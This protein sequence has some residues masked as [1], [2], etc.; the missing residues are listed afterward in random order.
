M[1][2]QSCLFILALSAIL[3]FAATQPSPQSSGSERSFLPESQKQ[4]APWSNIDSSR[5]WSRAEI[6]V[7]PLERVTANRARLQSLR[8]RVAQ[9]EVDS[10]GLGL[11]DPT[12]R[13]RHVDLLKELLRFAEQQESDQAENPTA[14]EVQRQL[15]QIEG[16]AMCEA[17]HRGIV[18]GVRP[19]AFQRK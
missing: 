2:L 18:A 8:Q 14:M 19:G 10:I 16:R 3:A 15:N 13:R 1:R 12:L 7:I 11:S 9:A 4:L 6:R 5:M 17:C